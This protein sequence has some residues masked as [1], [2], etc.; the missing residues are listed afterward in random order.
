MAIEPVTRRVVAAA[1][2]A[3]GA[4]LM[5]VAPDTRIGLALLALA[6]AIEVIGILLG[7]RP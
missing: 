7:R 1:L 3:F 5:A 6:V 4:V 2:G